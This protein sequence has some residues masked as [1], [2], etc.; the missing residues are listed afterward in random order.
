MINPHLSR[1]ASLRCRQIGLERDAVTIAIETI[2]P[3]VSCPSCG[4]P[5]GRIHSR[6]TRVLADLPWQG[7]L[8]SWSM[9]ARKFFC[10]TAA[11]PQRIFTERMAGIADA[12]ARK[13]ARLNEALV[14]V[15]FS[16]GGEGGARLA[17]PF[18]MP[19]GAAATYSEC[20]FVA[21]HDTARA[22]Y[23][24]SHESCDDTNYACRFS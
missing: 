4:Q 22:G 13:T 9:I 12:Y 14:C 8:V 20:A 7:P 15:A 24:T 6:Y 21:F 23:A 10:D 5:S 3:S 16:C 17:T 11:C 18:G 19:T 2:T 1:S